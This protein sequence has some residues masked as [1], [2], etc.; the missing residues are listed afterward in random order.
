MAVARAF[1]RGGTFVRDG[2]IYGSRLGGIY[3]SSLNVG[4]DLWQR[5]EEQAVDV[6]ENGGAARGDVV[7]G[8][9][10]V[11]VAEGVVDALSRGP[12]NSG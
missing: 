11:Q 4:V 12:A 2:H 3:D 5:A 10:L 1:S 6:G 8:E 9:K 7:L